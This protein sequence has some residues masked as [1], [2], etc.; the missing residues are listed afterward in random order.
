MTM[1]ATYLLSFDDNNDDSLIRKLLDA[2]GVSLA[3]LRNRNGASSGPLTWAKA[4]SFLYFGG[5]M[6]S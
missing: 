6:L 5:G 2:L 3:Q 1:R 4:V